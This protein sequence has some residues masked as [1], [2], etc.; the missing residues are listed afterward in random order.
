MRILLLTGGGHIDFS[1]G[2]KTVIYA[3]RERGNEILGSLD[4][5]AGIQRGKD[6]VVDITDYPIENLRSLGGSFLGS[7]R[8]KPD[9]QRVIDNIHHYGIDAV[10]AFGGEDT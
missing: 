9:L 7:S 2:L 8:T 6:G 1:S 5:W 3:Q 10:L 4:G